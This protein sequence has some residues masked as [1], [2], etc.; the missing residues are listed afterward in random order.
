MPTVLFAGFLGMAAGGWGAGALYDHF[1]FYLPAFG[2]GVIFN[3][4]NLF[5]LIWLA[6]CERGATLR[7]VPA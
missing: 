4:M 5:V 2:I 7:A 1:G 3:A 6:L